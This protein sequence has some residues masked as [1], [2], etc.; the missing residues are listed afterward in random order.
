MEGRLIK[1]NIQIGPAEENTFLRLFSCYAVPQGDKRYADGSTRDQ[2]RK[3]LYTI[4]QKALQP[5]EQKK[6]ERRKYI[7][8]ILVGDLQE[9]ITMTSRDNQGSTRY[10]RLDFGVL[11]AIDKGHNNQ[12]TSAVHAYDA[13]KSYIT[14]ENPSSSNGGRGISHIMTSSA[15]ED[16]YVGGCID[17]IVSSTSIVSDHHIVAAD[18]ILDIPRPPPHTSKPVVRHKWGK[19]A[20]ILVEL[21]YEQGDESTQPSIILKENTPHTDEWKANVTMYDDIHR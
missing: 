11:N 4:V 1:C 5:P 6:G 7:G 21:I 9:T 18:F 14:R 19:L 3:K 17:P 16:L 8:D 12:M 10:K 13:H 2:H 15:A 20:K